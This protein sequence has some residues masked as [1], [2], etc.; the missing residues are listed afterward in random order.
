MVI[1]VAEIAYIAL[2]WRIYNEFGWKV[3]K[4]LGADRRIKKMYASYQIFLCLVKFD[5]FFWVGFSVQFLWL[6]LSKTDWEYYVTWAALPLSVV[7]LIEGHLAAR[8]ESKWMMAT[9]MSGCIGALV[10]FV[11]KVSRF[12]FLLLAQAC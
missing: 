9:F 5:L 10:Y 7:L 4:F 12:F 3:Y 1:S 2:G 11:Y 6:V 8:H